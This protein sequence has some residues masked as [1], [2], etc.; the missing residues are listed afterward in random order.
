[1]ME[2]NSQVSRLNFELNALKAK[3]TDL[4][5]ET[6]IKDNNWHSL[7]RELTALK[8]QIETFESE[9]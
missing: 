9:M 7:N 6:E 2:K 1:M 5:S 4:E 3:Y 8:S